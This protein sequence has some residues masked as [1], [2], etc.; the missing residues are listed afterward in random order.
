MSALRFQSWTQS[1]SQKRFVNLFDV[2]ERLS[3]RT[4]AVGQRQ[5]FQRSREMEQAIID[6]VESGLTNPEWEGILYVMSWGT[7][8]DLRPL[9]VGKAGRRGR[10]NALSANIAKIRANKAKFAR[11]GDG[12]DYHIG[13]LS[14]AVFGGPGYRGPQEKYK[15]WADMLFVRTNPPQ[16]RETTSLLVIPWFSNSKGP[17]GQRLPLEAAEE[18]VIEL[19]CAEYEDLVLNVIGERWWNQSANPNARPFVE[20]ASR[21]RTLIHE[22]DAL[23][24][25][26]H[27]LKSVSRV[28]LDVETELYSQRLCLIQIATTEATYLIDAIALRNLAPLREILESPTILKIIHNATFE[29]RILGNCGIQLDGVF[30]TLVA[31]RQRYG[32]RT[33]NGHGL[34]V[35]CE[36][37]LGV[38]LFKGEQCSNWARRPLSVSQMEYAALDAE[39]LL[40]LHEAF[41]SPHGRQLFR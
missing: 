37:E 4:H 7:L 13:D 31:S 36:R 40:K 17:N 10:S 3:V 11:W 21:S 2:D 35:V 38:S 14:H 6:E 27:N 24:E 1:L 29:R 33:D 20:P 5:V 12:L 16:L 18:E 23:A 30:D 25:I 32:H 8:S 28:G 9:Y 19:A 15:K 34:S 39:V 26:A 22:P 41:T